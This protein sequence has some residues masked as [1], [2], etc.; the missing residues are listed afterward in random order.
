M[1]SFKFQRL[2]V[3]QKATVFCNQVYGIT[4]KWPREYSLD[5]TSQIRRAALS[6]PLNIAEG[7]SRT[8]KDFSRFI[9]IARGSCYECV[10]L[11]EIA[12]SLSLVPDETKSNLFANL[13]EISKML[14][15]LKKSINYEPKVSSES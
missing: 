7:T 8:K 13:E 4:K 11:V 1:T 10:A 3:Y 9:D 2:N 15:G 12:T 14:A 6:I 5:I